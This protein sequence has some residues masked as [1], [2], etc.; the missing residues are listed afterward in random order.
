MSRFEF[1]TPRVA[2]NIAA[3][4]MTLITIGVLVVLPAKLGSGSQEARP[5]LASNV[6]ATTPATIER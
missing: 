5:Q 2:C 3:L 6:V 4:A 1:A